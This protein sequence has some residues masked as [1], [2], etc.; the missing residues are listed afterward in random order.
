MDIRHI[1]FVVAVVRYAAVASVEAVVGIAF[2]VAAGVLDQEVA[3]LD[4]GLVVVVVVAPVSVFEAEADCDRQQDLEA[5]A[6]CI[7]SG[8]VVEE[9]TDYMACW[10]CWVLSR[11]GMC[12]STIFE[13]VVEVVDVVVHMTARAVVRFQSSSSQR[14]CHHLRVQTLEVLMRNFDIGV[15]REL[16]ME[17][18]TSCP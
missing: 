11:A 13:L 7:G 16:T 18:E 12:M 9:D 1:D 15:S 2:E 4:T 8:W 3:W 10:A 5:A 17:E 6:G 14:Q